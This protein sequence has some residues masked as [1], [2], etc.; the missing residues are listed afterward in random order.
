M[1]ND[2]QPK[3]I[4]NGVF[5][6]TKQQ[7]EYIYIHCWYSETW[8]RDRYAAF[9]SL[10]NLLQRKY[11]YACIYTYIHIYTCTSL[12]F[13]RSATNSIRYDLV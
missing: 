12:D 2:A 9:G 8:T 13:K 6:E 5:T 4:D 3:Y 11:I 1:G 7:N 10:I